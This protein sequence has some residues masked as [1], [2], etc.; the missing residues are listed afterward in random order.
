M[1]KHH[2]TSA[3]NVFVGRAY[4]PGV[5]AR[6]GACG[7]PISNI[8][9]VSLGTPLLADTDAVAGTQDGTA[10]NGSTPV[11]L[12][13]AEVT[14]D[15]PRNVTITSAGDDSGITFTVNGRDEYGMAMTEVI[16]GANAGL[17]SGKKAFKVVT[18]IQPSA[19]A[20]GNVSA[21][22]GDVLG[23]PYRLGKRADLL[24]QFAGDTE[25]SASSVV[26]AGDG[27]TATGTTGDVRGTINPNTALDGSTEIVVWMR[28][29]G[30]SAA[31]LGGVPQYA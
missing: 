21:G 19:A 31:V 7:A 28:V 30:R 14:L 16:T 22:F 26:V 2:L 15:V 6:H 18:R 27:A 5:H 23:L 3:D 24:A 20:A 29:D 9:Q 1:G 17:A 25:E 11:V 12:T 4:H 13:A 10:L 8:T